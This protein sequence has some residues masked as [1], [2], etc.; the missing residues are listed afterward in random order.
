[1]LVSNGATIVIGGLMQTNES[2]SEQGIPWLMRVPVL[3]AL[4]K[5]HSGANDRAELL[6][7]LTP[8]ILEEPRLS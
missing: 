5:S 8:T 3:G 6:I 7:F 1:M 2:V 4:F